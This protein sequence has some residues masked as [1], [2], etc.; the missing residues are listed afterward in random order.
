MSPILVLS[1]AALLPKGPTLQLELMP[2]RTLFVFGPNGSGKSEF[3]A[4]LLGER[5]LGQ[6]KAQIRGKAVLA[7][8]EVKKRTTPLGLAKTFS[9]ASGNDRLVEAL[10]ALGLWEV[11]NTPIASL[12]PAE[13][14]ACELVEGLVSKPDL[15]LIDHQLD[16][17][18]PWRLPTTLQVLQRRVASGAALV[19]ATNLPWLARGAD[20]IVVLRASE[21][22][23]SGSYPDLERRATPGTLEIETHQS[24]GVRA[25]VA[26]FALEVSETSAGL[27]VRAREGQEVAAKLLVE[28]YGD[29]EAV[30]V[31]R[32][33]PEELLR[34][35]F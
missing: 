32:P 18:D 20:Q 12:T 29:V 30:V 8:P 28:G 11:R 3:L 34:S 6:G 25:L 9:G 26:P 4:A 1:E 21:V 24:E 10:N 5:K 22:V 17:L 23:F 27:R 15:I 7:R 33:T 31:K 13:R 35:L 16:T 19:A 14:R 2:S